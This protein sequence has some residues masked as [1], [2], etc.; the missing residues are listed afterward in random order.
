MKEIDMT[1]VKRPCVSCG[2]FDIKIDTIDLGEYKNWY[3]KC[4]NCDS[5]TTM[6]H[7]IREDAIRQWDNQWC[8]DQLDIAQKAA[9]EAELKEIST[10]FSHVEDMRILQFRYE[11]LIDEYLKYRMMYNG[12]AGNLSQE[13]R[14]RVMRKELSEE[15]GW[16]I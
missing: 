14:R 4:N 13:D 5:V 16:T 3:V 2:K 11:K 8:W 1:E 12:T 7:A 15:L 6:T 9:K 10:R